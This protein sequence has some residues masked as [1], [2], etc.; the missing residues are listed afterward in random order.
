MTKRNAI[1][2]GGELLA[3]AVLCATSLSATLTLLGL[4]AFGPRD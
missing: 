1:V 4:V 3:S 2:V